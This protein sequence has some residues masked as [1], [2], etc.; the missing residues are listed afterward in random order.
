MEAEE[1]QRKAEEEEAVQKGAEKQKKA[2]V[3]VAWCKQLEL[4]LQRKVTAC[5]AQEEDAQRV[6]EASGEGSQSTILGY[7]KGKVLEKHVCMNC[8]RKGIECEWDEGGRGKSKGNIYIYIYI[9]TST[10][11]QQ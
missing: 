4:L 1:A 10:Q 3:S 5:I 6:S 8:L 11:K 2:E 9:L 7:G